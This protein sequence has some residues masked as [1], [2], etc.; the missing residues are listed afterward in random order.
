MGE[1]TAELIEV[2]ENEISLFESLLD[3]ASYEKDAME[4]FYLEEMLSCQKSIMSLNLDINV[5]EGRR[6]KITDEIAERRQIPPESLTL[7]DLVFEADGEERIRLERCRTALKN[8]L[9][10]LSTVLKENRQLASG[11]LEF[12]DRSIKVLSGYEVKESNYLPSGILE[13]REY[14]ANRVMKEV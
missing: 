13:Q 7:Q 6:K 8:L 5:L 4:N 9:E 12:L 3:A 14:P 10:S 2:L 11:S 1:R